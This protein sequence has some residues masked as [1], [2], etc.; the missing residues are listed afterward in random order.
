MLRGFVEKEITMKAVIST[1]VFVLSITT[2]SCLKNSVVSPSASKVQPSLSIGLSM[3]DAPA[4]IGSI[5]GVL[6]RS[7]LTR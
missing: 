6:T 4:D 3:K 1:L 5:V 7:G 2:L